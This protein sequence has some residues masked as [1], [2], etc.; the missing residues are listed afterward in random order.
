LI[1]TAALLHEF[2][3]KGYNFDTFI[4]TANQ[5]LHFYEFQLQ[6]CREAVD[7]WTIVALRNKVV[8][9]IRKMIGMIIWDSRE[10][11]FAY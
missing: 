9:D 1:K 3:A 10:A 6:S 8:K 5:A 11:H 7:S 4:G 2:M